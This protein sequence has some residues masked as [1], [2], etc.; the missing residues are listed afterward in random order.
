MP[1]DSMNPNEFDN[2]A[3]GALSAADDA[4][5]DAAAAVN[6]ASESAASAA[7]S[8]VDGTARSAESALEQLAN[9]LSGNA[10]AA[11]P[12]LAA[13]SL[14]GETADTPIAD[15]PI[16]DAPIANAPLAEAPMTQ[17]PLAQPFSD[18]NVQVEPFS[19]G[20]DYPVVEPVQEASTAQPAQP[21]EVEGQPAQPFDVEVQP[22]E[23]AAQPSTAVDSTD[24]FLAPETRAVPAPDDPAA[25]AETVAN[26]AASTPVQQPQVQ[27]AY[28]P[29]AYQAP[30]QQTGSEAAQ[31]YGNAQ[32]YDPMQA[33]G[34]TQSFEPDPPYG[35]AQGYRP[36]EQAAYQQAYQQTQQQYAQ[37]AAPQYVQSGSNPGTTPLVLG[38][39]SIVFAFLASL[40]G[41][42]LSIIGLVQGR[43]V[44]KLD[45]LNGRA[46]AGKITSIVGLVLSILS[47]ILG[48]VLV[49]T[50]FSFSSQAVNDPEGF[51][52]QMED[53]AAYD[54]TGELQDQI[55]A[56][57][58]ELGVSTGSGAAG[59][60]TA[61]SNYSGTG[62]YV[63]SSEDEAA[64]LAAVDEA[65]R[66]FTNPSADDREEIADYLDEA[67]EYYMTVDL[68]DT[69]VTK[70]EFT[71]WFL[72]S[73]T[74]K[75]DGVTLYS[76]SEGFVNTTV[77]AVDLEEF[78]DLCMQGG[79]GI[80]GA[81]AQE[82]EA[83][84]RD[85]MSKT[86]TSERNVLFDVVKSNGTWVCDEDSTSYAYGDIIG[87]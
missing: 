38:I 78:M 84:M 22:V 63:G 56:L 72:N 15:A 66:F 48:I 34:N 73:L 64:A 53:I 18:P 69:L 77:K 83:I 1:E 79:K 60:G 41:I 44:L 37:P 74:Y 26:A 87:I 7:G 80:A 29:A 13:D 45:P 17:A 36:N 81:N 46:K 32:N 52:S 39:L 54:D 27:Q 71:D 5:Q 19:D 85:A 24:A 2:A 76:D 61:G 50:L 58:E 6:D 49:A 57:K 16:A 8:V 82:A 11:A 51:I 67:I 20:V 43:K 59:S 30:V 33:Y 12:E 47:F 21:L 28:D 3:E 75:N 68:D 42:V 70:S 25:F 10:D 65:M 14:L 40:I 23:A 35:A 4:L 31:P 9:A 55:D 86:G 62:G